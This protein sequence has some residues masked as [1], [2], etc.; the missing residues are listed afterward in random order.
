MSLTDGQ[1]HTHTHG[2]LFSDG[3]SPDVQ[4]QQG[5]SLGDANDER[6]NTFSSSSSP[7]SGPQDTELGKQAA[8]SLA[9]SLWNYFTHTHTHSRTPKKH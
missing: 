4:Q 6:A 1:T 5:T 8:T 2:S 9:A 3:N 7:G